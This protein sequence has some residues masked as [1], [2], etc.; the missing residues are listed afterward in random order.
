MSQCTAIAKHTGERCR[1]AAVNGTGK[2]HYHGGK[3]PKGAASPHFKDGS[4]S[5]HMPTQ[6]AARHEQA[7]NDP[8]LGSLMSNIALREAFIRERLEALDNAPDP[9]KVWQDMTRQLNALEV[10]YSKP[11]PAGMAQAL[12][13][14]RGLISERSRYHQTRSE[15][16]DALNDQRKDIVDHENILHK[17]DNAVALDRLMVFMGQLAS[18]LIATI[19]DKTEL[20]K[21]LNG[22]DTILNQPDRIAESVGASTPAPNGTK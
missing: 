9:A 2:C 1:Q 3:T 8:E 12:R 5:K 15:I 22:V 10:A 19:T 16:E 6:L 4:R 20:N 18:L 7:R 21:V 14:M 11:D 13:A 17:G